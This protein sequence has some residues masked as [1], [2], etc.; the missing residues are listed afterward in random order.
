MPHR[1]RPCEP[2]DGLRD[3]AQRRVGGWVRGLAQPDPV[4]LRRLQLDGPGSG[5]CPGHQHLGRWA[6]RRLDPRSPRERAQGPNRLEF[7]HG[8]RVPAGAYVRVQLVGHLGRELPLGRGSVG[9]PRYALSHRPTLGAGQP[10]P[11]DRRPE[12]LRAA[13]GTL[14]GVSSCS[15]GY[16]LVSTEPN[17]FGPVSTTL[18]IEP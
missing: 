6:A 13:P 4:A 12:W 15:N 2:R 7:P 16:T 1:L 18:Q 3:V 9:G 17:P 8:A 14:S 5:A 10:A 11:V